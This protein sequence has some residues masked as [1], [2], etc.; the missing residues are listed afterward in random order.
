MLIF[1]KQ[2]FYNFIIKLF[3]LQLHNAHVLMEFLEPSKKSW[4]VSK[5][6]LFWSWC[7]VWSCIWS[8]SN[9]SLSCEWSKPLR[10]P[11]PLHGVVLKHR[12][13]FYFYLPYY[14]YYDTIGMID[15]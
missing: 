9:T 8:A 4:H 13:K 6:K 15:G 11:I 12:D 5:S 10:P 3:Y 14:Y 2:E 1:T 7:L